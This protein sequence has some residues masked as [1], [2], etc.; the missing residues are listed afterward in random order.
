MK[1]KG[2][3]PER[4]H[5]GSLDRGNRSP[6]YK[7]LRIGIVFFFPQLVDVLCDFLFFWAASGFKEVRALQSVG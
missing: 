2:F 5:K 4:T 3:T 1:R 7:I 6:K